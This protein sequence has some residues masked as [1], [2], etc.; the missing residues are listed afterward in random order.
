VALATAA[1]VTLVS[2]AA[3]AR[4]ITPAAAVT[5]TGS[6][7]GSRPSIVLVHGAWTDSS[8]W[9]AVVTRL[10][11]DGY[12]V[13]VPPNPLLGLSY[14]PAF[15]RDFLNTACSRPAWPTACRP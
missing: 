11:R 7:S 13:Y 12:T 1:L 3:S 14:H 9:D 4:T 10:Q 8:S 2:Q 15:L 5:K 6:A